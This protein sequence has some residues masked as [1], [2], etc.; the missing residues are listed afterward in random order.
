MKR[1]C[2]FVL[3][4]IPIFGGV[5]ILTGQD[6]LNLMV[7]E[8]P[9]TED[10]IRCATVE[11]NQALESNGKQMKKKDFERWMRDRL[12]QFKSKSDNQK[13]GEVIIY[14]IP[15]VVHVIHRGEEEGTMTNIAHDKIIDQIDQ[16]NRDF[17]RVLGTLG[18]NDHADGADIEIEFCP[19]LRD[20]E[21]N[22]LVQI[23]TN[24]VN[25]LTNGLGAGVYSIA[26][27]DDVVKRETIWNPEEYFNFWSAD[28]GGGVILG[29]A[30]FPEAATVEGIG[31]GNG[32]AETDGV[33]C[34]YSTIGGEDVPSENDP[35]NLGRTGTHETGHWL[36]L[37]HIWG[38]TDC[39][40]DDFVHDT[41][42]AEDSNGGCPEDANSCDDSNNP[43]FNG[44]DPL[45]MVKNYMDYTEDACMNVFTNGQKS[46]MRIV[47]GE[48]GLGSPRRE[49]LQFSRKCDIA[50]PWISFVDKSS[51]VIEGTD[52]IT[53]TIIEI[54]L[55]IAMAPTMPSTVTFD[56][57]ASTASG[58]D[59][60]ISSSVTFPAGLTDQQLLS[61]EI[62][63]D[64]SV[65]GIEFINIELVSVTGD[66]TLN[67]NNLV[68]VVSIEDDDFGPHEAAQ[69]TGELFLDEDFEDDTQDSEWTIITPLA[70]SNV[71]IFSDAAT[72]GGNTS[73]TAH[74][75]SDNATYTYDQ[76][77]ATRSIMYRAVDLTNTSNLTMSF[78]WS[79]IGEGADG[80]FDYGTV[81]YSLN[82]TDFFRIPGTAF[83][84]TQPMEVKASFTLPAFLQGTTP[85]IGFS[86]ENDELIG[87]GVPLAVDN[88]TI[89]GDRRAASTIRTDISNIASL[90]IGASETVHFYDPDNGQIMMSIENGLFPMGC[91]DVSIVE[92]GG[93]SSHDLYAVMAGREAASKIFKIEH[94]ENQGTAQYRVH[95]YYTQAEI[96]DWIDNHTLAVSAGHFKVFS[97][98]GSTIGDAD[99]SNTTDGLVPMV[100]SYSAVT[101]GGLIYSAVVSGGSILVG[102]ANFDACTYNGDVDLDVLNTGLT[103]IEDNATLSVNLSDGLMYEVTAGMSITVDT[104]FYISSATELL[105]NIEDCEAAL[106]VPED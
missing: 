8:L 67:N 19:V 36:G 88:V 15:T 25:A 106:E 50:E 52:C 2:L 94:S 41:P 93:G 64:A 70:G 81:V 34:L 55:K 102:G 11:Y 27:F 69:T 48:T 42:N 32:D 76:V 99:D 39:E 58:E 91:T 80:L 33:V 104:G 83:L 14:K 63:P 84:H 85:L 61:I 72:S 78:D 18:Y 96:Q 100:E 21:E 71:W 45:D 47:M 59:Y 98:T 26:D 23:G 73:R 12:S 82:G 95:L 51:S 28:L 6:V 13:S 20:P 65:E 75:S 17:R 4:V 90:Q 22:E 3:F 29:Y 24:R 37:R 40:G 74:I 92:A 57:T 5:T 10:L 87:T 53:P 49:I 86:W 1:V 46:R 60:S 31:T 79:C 89:T 16:L 103:S 77:S 7:D 62:T 30:Q 44:A 56:F 38:D 43:H 9:E 97:T 101:P 54:P 105:L 68:H 35:Y 66:A